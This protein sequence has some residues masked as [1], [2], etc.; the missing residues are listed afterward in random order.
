MKYGP[1]GS[2][3]KK[4]SKMLS[5]LLLPMLL[6]ILFQLV[7]FFSVLT[8]GGEFTFIQK[9]AYGILVEKTENRKSYVEKELQQKV[10]F[11]EETAAEINTIIAQK[12]SA[13]NTNIS[14]IQTDKE[15]NRELIGLSLDPIVYLMRRSLVNDVFLILETGD[16]YAEDGKSEA[17]AGI[18]LRDL[19]PTTDAG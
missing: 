12:L 3:T 6:L 7:T 9:Y 13:D 11:V 19:D 17:K 2:K 10:P 15:Y 16:L 1:N 14:R 4:K 18:Y 5:R 8:I